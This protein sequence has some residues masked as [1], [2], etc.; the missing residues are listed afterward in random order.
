MCFVRLFT[1]SVVP[2]AKSPYLLWFFWRGEKGNA[3]AVVSSFFQFFIFART[4]TDKKKHALHESLTEPVHCQ[5]RAAVYRVY[6]DSLF[7][8]DFFFPC[9]AEHDNN[10]RTSLSLFFFLSSQL[11]CSCLLSTSMPFVRFLPLVGWSSSFFFP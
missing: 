5:G 3:I 7:V 11:V 1:R 10:T 8:N 4:S 9:V 2:L 6:C